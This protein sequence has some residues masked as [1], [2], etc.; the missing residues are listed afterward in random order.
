MSGMRRCTVLLLWLCCTLAQAGDIQQASAT[1][2]Q[3]EAA[4][5]DFTFRG[6]SIH[7]RAVE[8]LLSW[9]ADGVAGTVAIDLDGTFNSNRYY[10]SFNRL[11]D[12]MVE[13]DRTANTLDKPHPLANLGWFRY[14]R[15]GTL[16]GK[17]HVLRIWNN[18]GGSLTPSD[19][20]L[21][22]FALDEEY[23][24]DGS[25]RLRLV[26]QRRGEIH[27]PLDYDGR[28]EVIDGGRRLRL[29]EPVHCCKDDTESPARTLR[30]D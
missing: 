12:G 26:M 15:L 23:R 28:I 11:D 9:Y 30:F 20:L 17:L 19:L 13:F 29:G 4:N 1:R 16:R 2:A 6:R 8:E 25:K 24:P 18:G 7:P 5:A 22:H 10:G 27:L 14:Q 3:L 21:V